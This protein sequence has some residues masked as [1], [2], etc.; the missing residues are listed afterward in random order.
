MRM[1]ILDN[2]S[3][4]VAVVLGVAVAVILP[5]L[6]DLVRKYF[7]PLGA[8]FWDNYRWAVRYIVLGGFSIAV[9]AVIYFEW[10]KGHP[11]GVLTGTDGFLLGFSGESAIEKMF[12]PK[13][14]G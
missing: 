14:R 13:V 7:P 5:L 8:G 6:C 12:R 2:A 4:F 1:S 3:G 10:R 11:T 9:G